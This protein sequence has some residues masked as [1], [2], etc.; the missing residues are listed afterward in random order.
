MVRT[1]AFR[2]GVAISPLEIC[3]VHSRAG[4]AAA[5]FFRAPLEPFSGESGNWPSLAAAFRELA[6]SVSAEEGALSV[7]LLAPL[8]EV[9]TLELPP[10]REPELRA[11]LT[12]NAARYFVGAR[13]P[14]LVGVAWA[15]R[16]RGAVAP[17][18]AAAAPLRLI[19]AIQGA[20]RDSG[21]LVDSVTPAE[22]AWAKAATSAW[23][24]FAK[25]S[26]HLLVLHS[27]RTDLVQLRDGQ[28]AAVRRFRTG[29]GDAELIADAV[30]SAARGPG[31]TTKPRVAIIG[32][33]EGR[34]ELARALSGAGASLV[35]PPPAF[36]EIAEQPERF[37]AAFAAPTNDLALR[38]DEVR[39]SI[40]DRASRVAIAIASAAGV[41]VLLSG[42][43]E[44][45]G[46]KRE[47]KAVTDERAA[48]KPR[49]SSTL[50]GRTS[51]ETAYSQLA[52]L[53]VAE[54]AAPQWS[55][56]LADVTSHLV[57][58]SYLTAFRARGD[59]VVVDGIAS[60][61]SLVFGDFEKTPGLSN[62][63][64]AAPVR[65]EAPNGDEPTEKFTIAAQL[66]GTAPSR[67]TA[68]SSAASPR[69]ATR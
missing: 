53:G 65:R 8:V 13:S 51:I 58:D 61:A 28:V 4:N 17:M 31:V 60:H 52:T 25:Q 24:A 49:L 27:D 29:S 1:R 56:V 41:F 47:L 59:S 38:T 54:R 62:V 26:A 35:T 39:A 14:Q 46:V 19:S 66:N 12:R 22:S 42:A 5:S 68:A 55:V 16:A 18:V 50:V 21:W 44:M 34:Q 36:A 45:W 10:L 11:L 69:G 37:A 64:F 43:F 23:P 6:N 30:V 33:A 20:A 32:R 3:A 63:R 15:P 67:T 7:A 57:S 2:V 48:L 9:R 40:D